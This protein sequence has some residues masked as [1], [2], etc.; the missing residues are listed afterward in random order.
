MQTKLN[1]G[2]VVHTLAK[3]ETAPPLLT[4][5]NIIVRGKGTQ[6]FNNP[7]LKERARAKLLTQSVVLPIIDIAREHGDEVME[8]QMWEYLCLSG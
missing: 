6:R 7:A 4:P 5:P 8:D 1:F 2:E 3:S